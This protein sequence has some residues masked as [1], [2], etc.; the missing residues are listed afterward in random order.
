MVTKILNL[1]LHNLLNLFYHIFTVA[2]VNY[3]KAAA[4]ISSLYIHVLLYL[5]HIT[6]EDN[7]AYIYIYIYIYT[8]EKE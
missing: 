5:M 3:F 6:A 4:S 2:F 1:L 7:F 8:Y